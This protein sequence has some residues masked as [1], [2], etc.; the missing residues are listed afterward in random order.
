MSWLRSVW[1]VA[2][3]VLMTACASST[4]HYHT[5]V[6]AAGG[7]VPKSSTRPSG[8]DVER[9]TVPAEVDRPELVVRRN[10]GEVALLD[11]ELWIAPLADEVKGAVSTEIQGRLGAA[12]PNLLNPALGTISIRIEVERF[13]SAP[14]RYSM[15][16]VKWQLRV[17]KPTN[18]VMLSCR[19]EVFERVGSGYDAMVIGH[20]RAIALIA[21]E[22]AD[23]MQR[24][25]ADGATACPLGD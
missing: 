10:D 4:L 9:V 21:D 11:G 8:V 12:E 5:L 24:L 23:S 2:V 20:R 16:E 18:A 3:A 17:E 14:A 13:E 7:A 15:I 6:P 19:S 25:A 1:L 22:M